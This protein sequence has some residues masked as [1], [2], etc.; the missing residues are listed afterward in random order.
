ML[1]FIIFEL[2]L[3]ISEYYRKFL[4]YDIQ[5]LFG[6]FN[7]AAGNFAGCTCSD[8]SSTAAAPPPQ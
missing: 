5:K 4:K 2:L 6:I 8:A 3:L 7:G 1:I